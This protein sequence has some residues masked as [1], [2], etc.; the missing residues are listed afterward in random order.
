MPRS[1]QRSTQR[2]RRGIIAAT[3]HSEPWT[4]G[5]APP[6][7]TQLRDH[8]YAHGFP[9]AELL[10]GGLVTTARNGRVI[11]TFRDR[12]MFPIRNRDGQVVA[13]TGRDLSGRVDVPKYRNTT[14]TVI[15]R[16][17]ELLY[18]LAE[19]L[20]GDVQPAAVML[21]EG[22]ADVVAVAR[23]RISI[24]A[25]DYPDP[26]AAVAP[27]GTALTAAQVALLASVVPPG[28]P[29]VVAFDADAAGAKAIDKS[30]AL[31]HDWPGPV[32]AIALPAGSDPAA[33][34]AAGPAQALAR[35]TEARTGLVDIVV[36]QRLVPYLTRLDTR[37]QELARFDRDPTTE[38]A[39]IRLDAVHAVAS[40]LDDAARRDSD[41][42][43]QLMIEVARR[44]GLEPLTV[45]ETVYPP[46][47]EV[48][49]DTAHDQPEPAGPVD[50]QKPMTDERAEARRESIALGGPGFPDPSVVGHQYARASP[51]DAPAATWVQHDPNTGHSAWVLA[52]GIG[53]TPADREA[54]HL[55][56]QIAGRTAVLVGAHKAVQIARTAL[57]AHFTQ[58][59]R[60]TPGDATIA[61]LSSFDGEH[62]RPGHGRFT[63][64]WAG[65]TR[66]YATTGRWFSALTVDHTLREHG[67]AAD[68]HQRDAVAL[69][70][71]ADASPAGPVGPHERRFI[72]RA[73]DRTWLAGADLFDLAAVWRAAR[74]HERHIATAGAVA[75]AIEDRL[76]QTYP[77]AMEHYDQAVRAGAERWEAMRA[78]AQHLP[79]VA[80]RPGDGGL[81]SSVRGGPIGVNRIDLPATQITLVSRNLREGDTNLLR[82]AVEAHR[83]AV[84]INNL[85][86]LHAAT[87][88]IVVR[89]RPDQARTA[90]TAAQVARQDQAAN[91]GRTPYTPTDLR[92][93][94]NWPAPSAAAR[95]PARAR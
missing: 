78:A 2:S 44:L 8:L 73:T 89:P 3:A 61:V 45:I 55:A 30:Y 14:T 86:R 24:P 72:S 43:A 59:D 31:L 38:A 42:G 18:G 58:C 79:A 32:Q 21:V 5:Y 9:D 64:A 95:S 85:R 35:F 62:P 56:A 23:L 49:P 48:D 15:Y 17:S 51:P 29:V 88:A 94:S 39:M 4:I 25:A 66:A 65:D 20:G 63:V 70:S 10:A 52:E 93:R 74:A 22:P 34:V 46:D 54:A 12:V 87:A 28:T 27:C 60:S 37:L 50:A 68:Q 77:K 83:P 7:W 80:R 40:L 91:A 26:Y 6:G 47:D 53:D 19:Q 90:M 1:C 71:E 82:E 75:E 67:T 84:A 41:H 92:D 16:K 57:N 36:E 33:L 76:R 81:T 69:L 13:F 11:D